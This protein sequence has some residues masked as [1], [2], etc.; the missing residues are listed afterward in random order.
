MKKYLSVLLLVALT[1]A[2]TLSCSKKQPAQVGEAIDITITKE[3]DNVTKY[4]WAFKTKPSD[5]KLDPRDFLPSDDAEAVSFVPDVPGEYEIIVAMIDGDGR[6][7]NETFVYDVNGEAVA[8][9][10]PVA[11]EEMTAEEP[12]AVE[13]EEEK[14]GQKEVVE[15]EAVAEELDSP[16]APEKT[17]AAEPVKKDSK[18]WKEVPETATRVSSDRSSASKTASGSSA[19]TSI[20]GRKNR[21][22]VQVG[23]FKVYER[24][25][26]E[27]NDLKKAGFDPIIQRAY[28]RDTDEIWYRVRIGSYTSKTE[29]RVKITEI[30]QKTG[31]DCW[32]DNIREDS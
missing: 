8:V 9:D 27:V 25:Q 2:A 6:E 24:A 1:V 23:S 32:I 31:R 4:L 30:K 7:Y 17:A 20:P 26:R 29:A 22:T 19:A 12:A 15:T 3:A 16:V 14:V 13:P 5:S 11:E 21:F 28:F 10:S 18:T